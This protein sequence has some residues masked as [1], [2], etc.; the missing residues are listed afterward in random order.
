MRENDTEGLGES[1][2][3]KTGIEKLTEGEQ[4]REDESEKEK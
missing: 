2:R 1:E 4:I 3:D